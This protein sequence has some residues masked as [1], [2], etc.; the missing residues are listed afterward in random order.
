MSTTTISEPISNADWFY[1]RLGTATTVLVSLATCAIF[2]SIAVSQIFLAAALLALLLSRRTIRFPTRLGLALLAFLGWTLLSVAFSGDVWESL[3]Q[4]RKLFVFLTLVVAYNAYTEPRQIW[5]TVQGIVLGGAV[6]ALY[7]LVQ[8]VRTYWRITGEGRPFY[9]NYILHQITGFMG[10]W[11]TFG[12]QLMIVLLLAVSG[13]LYGRLTPRMRWAA[14]LCAAVISLGI[15]GAFT[16]GI[17]VGAFAGLVY[18]VGRYKLRSLW[19]LS[20]AALLLFLLSPSWLR[21]R[22]LSILNAS[23]DSS[24]H[25]RVVMLWTGLHMI[26]A[27]PWMGVGPERIFDE[28]LRY[29]PADLPLPKAWYGHLHNN[30]LQLAAARGIP[31]LLFWLW[32]LFEVFRLSFAVA[33]SPLAA[34]RALGHAAIAV[35]VALMVS[36]LFEF[37]LGDSEV[38]MPY[39]FLLA[40]VFAWMRLEPAERRHRDSVPY[41]NQVSQAL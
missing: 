35:S 6:A 29:K 36:G 2:F 31:C 38:L 30:Y 17:W 22:D 23:T 12:G 33:R 7:G 18:L 28:F 39:L 25:S 4:V 37:N 9:D 16:R 20:A 34:G 10:H 11:L 40:A 15:L 24:N 21:Q 13:A 14:W 8:F 26:A 41:P 19:L 5:R 27:H 3:A 1:G 32:L